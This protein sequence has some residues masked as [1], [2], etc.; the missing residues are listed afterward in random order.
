MGN[1][2]KYR[3]VGT[4]HCARPGQGQMPNS[5]T[6]DC[7]DSVW[8]SVFGSARA[9]AR[10]LTADKRVSTVVSLYELGYDECDRI[11][12]AERWS[13]PGEVA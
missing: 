13:S 6:Y 2:I 4:V 12:T 10:F 9:V 1:K 3:V 5:R 11:M 7:D 8:L